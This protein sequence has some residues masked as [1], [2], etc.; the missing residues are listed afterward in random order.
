MIRISV[1]VC[2]YNRATLVR[3]VLESLC[4]QDIDGSLYE[5]IVVDNNSTDDT[6]RVVESFL[7]HGG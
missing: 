6:R 2:T 4:N 5:I 1:I 3:G 7:D